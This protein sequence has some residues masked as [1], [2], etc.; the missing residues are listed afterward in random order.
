MNNDCCIARFD[1]IGIKASHTKHEFI[2]MLKSQLKKILPKSRIRVSPYRIIIFS[3]D[4]KKAALIASKVFGISSASPAIMVEQDIDL[5]KKA[6]Y[7]FYEKGK[8]F[9]ITC[10]RSDKGFHLKSDEICRLVGEYVFERGGKVSLKSFGTNICIDLF[11]K[12][13]FIFSEK[14][15][16]FGGLPC[17]SQGK[18]ACLMNDESDY[19]AC[20]M[21]MNRGC[22]P[23]VVGKKSFCNKLLKNFDYLK[24]GYFKDLNCGHYSAIVSGNDFKN[25]LSGFDCPVFYPLAFVDKKWAKEKFKDV[26]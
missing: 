26:N 20:L 14:I 4:A 15:R 3:D 8:S 5:I 2:S 25:L 13:A 12:K 10:Q 16:G 1:E 6:S 17:G 22:L 23:V 19:L 24:I 18:V 9:R 11:D 21:I 7:R